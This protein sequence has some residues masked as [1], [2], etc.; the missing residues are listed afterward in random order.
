M[1]LSVR[2]IDTG[3]ARLA[4]SVRLRSAK[5]LHFPPAAGVRGAPPGQHRGR[6][7]SQ[8]ATVTEYAADLIILEPDKID[9]PAAELVEGPCWDAGSQSLYWVDIPAARVHRLSSTGVH[10]SWDVGF[11]TGA[12]VPRASGGLV[13]A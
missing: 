12:V 5:Y 9:V 3:R 4:S 2:A 7:A 8:G 10:S 6:T 1:F 11:E 13:V